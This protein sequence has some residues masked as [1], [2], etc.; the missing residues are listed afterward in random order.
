MTREQGIEMVKKYTTIQPKN[1]R[2][3]LEWIGITENSFHYLI[4]QHRNKKIWQRNK[5]WEWELVDTYF[6]S[7]ELKGNVIQAAALSLLEDYTP[8]QLTAQKN[9][10]DKIDEYILIGKGC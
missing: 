3:F 4:D 5:N 7:N 10:S 8:F 2:L 1:L 9:S 6:P